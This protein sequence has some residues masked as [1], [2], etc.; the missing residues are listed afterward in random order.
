MGQVLCPPVEL[1]A[2]HFMVML[3]PAGW[4]CSLS[5]KAAGALATKRRIFMCGFFRSYRAPDGYQVA[6]KPTDPYFRN[7]RPWAVPG[8]AKP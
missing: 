8:Y 7:W 2:R 4:H 6:V 5:H 3:K 1:K